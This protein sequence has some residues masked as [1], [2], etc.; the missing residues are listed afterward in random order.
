M[1][2]VPMGGCEKLLRYECKVEIHW[3]GEEE[4]SGKETEKGLK[5]KQP[6]D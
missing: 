3:K 2:P 1:M 5:G 6:R 4:E